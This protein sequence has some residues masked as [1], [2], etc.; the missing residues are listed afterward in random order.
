M[1]S[2][3]VRDARGQDDLTDL[4]VVE[5]Y[6]QI[7]AIHRALGQA[8][9]A[10][11][12][13]EKALE[14]DP[15]HEPSHQ[16]LVELFEAAGRWDVALDHRQRLLDTLD[17][18]PRFLMC[19]GIAQLAR[20][21][22]ADPYQAIDAY[23][24]A[25]RILPDAREALEALLALYL[26][27]KQSQKAVEVL[28]RLIA[29]P[30][31]RDDARALKQFHFKLA[32]VYRDEVKDDGRAMEHFNLALDADPTF[33]D[34]FAALEGMLT[35]RRAWP[36]L[37]QSYHAM[38]RRLP[39]TPETH[40]AR[41]ALWRNLGELYRRALKNV[42]G[43]IMAFEVV[44]KAEPADG[45]VTETLADLYASKPGLEGKA[46]EAHRTSLR[47][48]AQPAR[49]V[50]ALARLHAARKEYDEAF[51][52]SQVAVHLL[53]DR[54]P[55]EEQ[56]VERLKRYARETATRPM[57][58]RLWT[59]HLYHERLRG[60]MAEVLS[61]CQEATGGA[62]AVDH[63]RLNVNPKRDRVDVASSML[64]FVNM[65]KYVARTLSMEAAELF[66][67]P[68]AAGLVLGNTWPV[69]FLAGEDMFKD[70]PKKELWFAIAKAMAFSRP[71]L[72]MA[73]LHPPEELEAIFQ[74]ALYLAVPSFRPT[75]DPGEL[76][77][78]GRKLEKGLSE[79]A[80]PALFRAARE[81]LKDPNQT[82]LR[83]YIEAVEHT[84]N[85]AG[86]LLCADVEVAK[87]C[88]ARDPGV[89]ARLPE[90]SKVRDLMLFCLSG[91][92]FALRRALGLAIDIP[93]ADGRAA[94]QT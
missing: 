42:D 88:L 93:T 52:T 41:L 77:R 30:A 62:F 34:A 36:A 69:C 11:K 80:R 13:F 60:P 35:E 61:I 29:A 3:L 63:G 53:G 91:N 86:I 48:T 8:D 39:K 83:G 37:E 22:L 82:E 89:A 81:C 5:I 46:I 58:D 16:A 25:L 68:G 32:Q 45:Q 17:G 74:A 26:E 70:R 92:F 12:D 94:A 2:G 18:E 14:L 54:D 79:T 57:T 38:I 49:N 47:T 66:K 71:E 67:V 87:R 21:H 6:W 28:E 50:K 24:Q 73:R 59:E 55:D 78:Q 19:V 9:R 56:V 84:A 64:F 75:A 7:G 23:L 90:R 65:Y 85:R 31:V 76:Q 51:V 33:I 10:Q 44:S 72:A 15:G 4:E 40:Q 20:D 43:A 27:T 1:Q